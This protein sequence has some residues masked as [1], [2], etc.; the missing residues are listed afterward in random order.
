MTKHFLALHDFSRNE[1]DAMLALAADLKHKQKNRVPHR[2]LE[3]K[4]VV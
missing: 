3:R 4:S 2:L 1:L